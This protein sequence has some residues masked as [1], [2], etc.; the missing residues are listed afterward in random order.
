MIDVLVLNYNDAMTTLNY[1]NKIKTYKNVR[2]ILVVDNFSTDNSVQL[3]SDIISEK[4]EVIVSNK[5]G[6][7]GAGNNYGIKYL[8]DKYNSDYILLS[9]PDV[10][11][12]DETINKLEEFLRNNQDYVIAAPFMLDKYR[13]RQ[14]NTAFRIPNLWDYILSFD[15]VWSK[16]LS[17]YFYKDI[18]TENVVYKDVDGVSGS[19][20]MMNAKEML[21]HGMY[22]E[23]I[24]LYCEEISLAIKLKKE[25][26]KTALL[27][28]QYFIHN[29]SVSISK[30]YGTE[31][32]RHR[33]LVN[34]KL[35]VIKQWYNASIV[36][37]VLALIMSRISLVEIG[38]WSLVHKR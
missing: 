5:N 25:G 8:I 37:Y 24:F 6:G 4:V 29:H 21:K 17:K 27:P 23:N 13:N 10:I 19:M 31:I 12:E 18:L 1:V 7:Y 26:K 11:V 16:W 15:L 14:I 32:K 28:R 20:F 9:N 33:L 2:H 36:T 35:Y 3:L 22:D 38:L 30:S 34:S